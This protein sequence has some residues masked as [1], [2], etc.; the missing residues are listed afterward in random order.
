MATQATAIGWFS[1]RVVLNQFDV[2]PTVLTRGVREALV[3]LGNRLVAVTYAN[4]IDAVSALLMSDAQW[5]EFVIEPTAGA[6]TEWVLTHPTK[7]YYTDVEPVP[8]PY[9]AAT[10]PSST[11]YC[12][13][14]AV[15]VFDRE[16]RVIS[17]SGGSTLLC[18][19]SDVLR[20]G[21]T[22]G[23][24]VLGSRLASSV[25]NFTPAA[26]SGSM[27]LKFAESAQSGLPAVTGPKLAGLPVIGFQ[28]VNYINGNVTPGVLANY[29]AAEPLRATVAC[30]DANGASVACP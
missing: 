17:P 23:A 9:A 27:R 7:H 14:Y 21:S 16:Q 2:P 29:A 15:E 19:S 10:R 3:G 1:D 25:G 12:L 8:P 13:P 4:S 11:T 18:S 20:F 28:V 26:T 24:S 5:G 22:T 6:S 30:A